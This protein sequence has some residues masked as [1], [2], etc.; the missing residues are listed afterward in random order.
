MEIILMAIQWLWYLGVGGDIALMI[1]K[2]TGN[3][4]SEVIFD[5]WS[6]TTVCIMT[7]YYILNL[8]IYCHKNKE[9]K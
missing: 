9:V 5:I 6:I 7:I 3:L 2:F 4:G 1:C 8:C